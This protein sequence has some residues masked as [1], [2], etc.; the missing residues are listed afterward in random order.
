[1]DKG[2]ELFFEIFKKEQDRNTKDEPFVI[3]KVISLNPL[4]IKDGDFELYS[5]DLIINPYLLE[6]TENVQGTMT[7]QVV[8]DHGSHSHTLLTIKHPSKLQL[9]SYVACYG[10]EYSNSSGCYQKYIVMVV[11]R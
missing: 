5:K 2:T 8:G 1:M 7:G 10:T 4:V 6:W 11:I 9:N 3:G